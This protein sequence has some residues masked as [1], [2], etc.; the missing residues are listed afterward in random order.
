MNNCNDVYSPSI[1][2]IMTKVE[3]IANTNFTL[4]WDEISDQS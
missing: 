3:K 1:L 4:N 2:A